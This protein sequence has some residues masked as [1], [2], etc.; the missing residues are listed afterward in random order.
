MIKNSSCFVLA[1]TFALVSCWWLNPADIQAQT[2]SG[3]ILGTIQD[4]QGAVIANAEVT[5]RNQET[6][7]VRK[8]NTDGNGN[9]RV[10][11]VQAGTYE[12]S[13]TANGFKTEVRT[14]VA[15]TVGG[16]STVTFSLTVGAVTEKIEV[17]EAAAQVDTASSTLGGFV[18]SETIRE[19][20]LNGRDWL[21]LALLQPGVFMNT[22]QAQNDANR[23]QKGNGMSFSISGGRQSENGYRI[24]GIIVNDYANA[25]PG[26]SLR[27]NMGV[28]AIREFSVLTNSY[29][30]EYGR[31]AGGVVNAIT[32]SGTND[33]HGSGF[34]FHRNSALDARNFF[35]GT[36]PAKGQ[37]RL[38]AFHRHQVGGALGGPIKKDKTFFFAN[39]ETLRELKGLSYSV[40]TISDA[41][42]N[43]VVCATQDT[44]GN[45]L[46]TRSVVIADSA[47]PYLALFPR[48]NGPVTG[49]TG[50]F[51]SGPPRLGTENYVTGKIDHNFS[52]ATT[53]SGTYT[54]D[55]SKVNSAES[56]NVRNVSAPTRRNYVALNLQHIFSPTVINS[57]RV[58]VARTYAGNNIDTPINPA[59]NDFALGFL[60]G[61]RLG[62]IIISGLSGRLDGI[63]AQGI[64]L[65]GHTAPQFYQDL[66][67]T[68]GRHSLR[69]GFGFERVT[70]NILSAG[71]PGGAF[72]FG[73]VE[74]FLTTNG[75]TLFSSDLPGSD[76][77]RGQRNSIIA[78]YIQDDYRVRSNLTFNLGLRYEMATVLTEVNGK[79]GNLRHLTD[80]VSTVG[81]PYW[82]NPT[83]KNFEPRI[84]F[85]WDPFKTGKTSIRGGFGMFDVLPLPY[86]LGGRIVRA[87]PFFLQGNFRNPPASS[88]PNKILP[89]LNLSAIGA[90]MMEFENPRRSYRMQWNLNIQRQLT[91]TLALTVGY[92]GSA[93]V[94][95]ANV[96]DDS[97]QVPRQFVN[98]DTASSSYRFPT[99]GTIQR[100]NPNFSRI[101]S[102]FWDQHSSYNS[103]QVN[104]VQRPVKGLTYQVAYTWSKS[105]DNGSVTYT[106]SESSNT[107]GL[108]W[109]FCNV[110]NRA[111]SDF[112]IPHNL[113]V[114]YLYDI[115]LPAAAR[116]NP[117]VNTVFGGWQLGGIYSVQTGAP[118]TI[119]IAS[120][121]AR[122]GDTAAPGANGAQKPMYV[123]AAGCNP[124][125]ST[126]NIN[127]LIKTSCFAFP[128]LGQL[129]NLGRNTLRMPMFRNVDFSV[130]KNQNLF[131]EKLK[132]QLRI[133]MFN[134]LNNTNLQAQLRTIFDANGN[135]TSGFGTPAAPTVTTSRQIQFGLRLLF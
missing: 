16:D 122:T 8:T 9:Y 12:V 73:T 104:L 51:V 82:R 17:S 77:S 85:A 23:A 106:G 10:P 18:N 50:K 120:D 71:A 52:P 43:G 98:F 13:A 53:L 1:V 66:S 88:F 34:Y 103:L 26:S 133:E 99:T 32:K 38:P 76:T 48:A 123:A 49:N 3:T 130:F 70:S 46:T 45:C 83:T 89:L 75:A 118:Y 55:D 134:V 107:A 67:W 69:M 2:V 74:G 65:F 30:A 132:A 135:I 100:I 117:F 58:G 39:Y 81:D 27:V 114:N 124:N 41:A 56:F 96:N 80:A 127:S 5:A 29:S 57:F 36:D 64:N 59:L 21:Q 110:C 109:F 42:R 24:D 108:S 105:I 102:T 19:L 4:Q 15:V 35:D 113:V 40:D 33:L 121:R 115:P 111:P 14:A 87:P 63:G 101:R 97:D 37:P 91:R 60:P 126:G 79:L 78:G 131:G 61:Q 116:M 95:L 125:A 112:N 6:G 31:G 25:G 94:H 54:F 20:P 68:K 72:T 11:S 93:G 86:L 90:T 62:S 22:G 7:I 84:G 129:G 44:I 47:K 119:K 128:E 28:D 92:V